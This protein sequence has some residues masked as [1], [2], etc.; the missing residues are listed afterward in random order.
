MSAF[1]QPPVRFRRM[2]PIFCILKLWISTAY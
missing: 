1:L 2:N